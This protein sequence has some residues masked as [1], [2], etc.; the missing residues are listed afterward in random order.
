[1]F[2]GCRALK[3][4]PLFNTSNFLNMS[5]MF[6]N[7]FSLKNVP[8]FDTGNCTNMSSMFAGC[9]NLLSVPSFNTSS[10]TD[11][12]SMFNGCSS[13]DNIPAFDTVSVINMSN[14][15][16]NCNSLVELIDSDFSAGRRGSFP[17]LPP[18]FNTSSVT[19]MQNM[20]NGCLSLKTVA[21]TIDVGTGTFASK[22]A[23]IFSSC[24]NLSLAVLKLA[25][26]SLSLAGCNMSKGSLEEAMDS[27]DTVA[28]AGQILTISNNP[29]AP[30]PISRNT[31]VDVAIVAGSTI[32][33]LQSTADLETGM[34]FTGAG[35]PLT[36]GRAVTFADAG[37]IVTL[38]S[39][40]LENG[41][42][43]SF[44]SITTTTGIVI[45][46]IYTVINKTTDTFQLG[47]NQDT[48][49]IDLISNGSGTIRYSSVI[50]SISGSSIEVSRPTAAIAPNTTLSFRQLSTSI[51]IHKGWSITG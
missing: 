36:T 12:S 24:P 44:S 45:N 23:G 29:A 1:M 31:S 34:Q 37:D 39:H 13:I 20:F 50:T 21:F 15:F 48:L 19:N 38:A 40:G 32:I 16:T 49:P 51:A 7:C 33:S 43:V 25:K 17:F 35:S 18:L 30:T 26:Y 8:L 22:F 5:G 28:A 9:S 11:M 47:E 4:V 41:D 6:S 3:S 27:L 10:V 46:K 2:T 42:T 14:M